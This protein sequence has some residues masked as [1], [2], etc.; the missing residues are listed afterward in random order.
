MS[1]T[2]P[3]FDKLSSHNYDGIQEYDNPMPGWWVALFIATIIWALGYWVYYQSGM[4][5]R[6]V[7]D[8]YS[9]AQAADLKKRFAGMGTLTPTELNLINWTQ[10]ADYML[11]GQSVFKANCVS[12][13]GA[14]GQGLVGFGV[15]L[16]DNFAKNYKK[17]TD[18][19]RVIANGAANGAMPA[20]ANR[21]HP[22]EI[23]LVA[24]Y[25]A[26]LRGQNIPGRSPDGDPLPA[27]P[28]PSSPPINAT[29]TK[30]T[31]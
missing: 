9:A 14:Q 11:V 6:S 16:T 22:N 28:K 20:W 26:S 31:N 21:L 10:N 3:E 27:W 19:P 8:D 30:P 4:P 7:A 24:S 2:E 25:V 18:I 5:D 29:S 17:V 15:N 1:T 12:C 23:A 13:H